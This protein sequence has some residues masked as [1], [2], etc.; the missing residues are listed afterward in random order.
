M[1]NLYIGKNKDAIYPAG[2]YFR[3]WIEYDVL[4]E[5]FPKKVIKEIDKSDVVGSQLII[6]PVLG[7]ISPDRISGGS[8]ALIILY[9]TD[10]MMDID[11]MGENCYPYLVEL[12]DK[13]DITISM[14]HIVNL[15]K[16]GFKGKIHVLNDDSIV[17]DGR[18]LV[19]KVFDFLIQ[20]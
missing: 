19:L 20:E 8:K 13:K 9:C 15:Y 10:C 6:S 16:Y 1:L 5:D 7:P 3:T 14:D 2:G 17:N 18:D 11:S 12:A 4:M